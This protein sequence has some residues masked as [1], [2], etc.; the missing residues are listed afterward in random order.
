MNLM[1]LLDMAASG[2]PD[3]VALG[4]RS[5]G[6][7][8]AGLRDR[9]AS[10]AALVESSGAE[11]VVYV[12]PNGPAF[13]LSLFASSWAGVPFVPLNFRLGSAQLEATINASVPTLFIGDGASADMARGTGQQVLSPQEF[14][15]RTGERV[16]PPESWSMDGEDPAVL[17]RTSGTT[18]AP[19]EAILRQRHLVSYV[20]GNV[21]F[22]VAEEA[23]AALV[24]VPPYHIAGISSVL[25][26]VYSGRR[27]VVLESFSPA[28][29]LETVRT[30]SI[31][32]AV[33]VPTMLSR[34][35]ESL[36]GQESS[37]TPSLRSLAYG[38]ARMPPGVLERALRVFPDTDFVNAYGL[39][40]TSSTVALLDPD[41]H[42]AAT[43]SN[44]PAVRARL[45]SVGRIVPGI[46]AEI[47]GPGGTPLPTGHAGEIWLRGKQIS[48]EYVGRESV[49]DTDG[50]YP[51]R[52]AGRLDDDGYLF[53]D[54]RSD[55]TIIR[56]G[57]N[58]APAE[59]EDVL[60]RHPAVLDAAVVGPEDEEWGQRLAA[61]IVLRDGHSPDPED[62]RDWVRKI[63]RS[64]KT[65][66]QIAFHDKI[67]HT[68]T[69]KPI[70]REI[71]AA[72]Q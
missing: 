3:R 9:A 69:G 13:S 27:I 41:D 15:Q 40:E 26:N 45:S 33:V 21:E 1:L 50:W 4:S 49:T 63:L 17:L 34:V 56:G 46:E 18:A 11:R 48:G 66:D 32:N 20:M 5:D 28:G 2:F 30:E 58:I 35:V 8:Y 57:E 53:V 71:L 54:G 62:I 65:P 39:T 24:A 19:K 22:G 51:T 37:R 25:S 64:S 38:G 72:L 70:R 55:D 68:D 7:T 12:A 14:I 47:R 31:T 23:D 29:W 43:S 67:P 6:L 60:R 59:I 10:G 52:D 44:D 16:E 36:A 61:M 42:R